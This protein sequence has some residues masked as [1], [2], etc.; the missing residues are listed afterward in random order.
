MVVEVEG[1]SILE[2][3]VGVVEVVG[4]RLADKDRLMGIRIRI[5]LHL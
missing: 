2:V 4:S 3:E 1:D 5:S